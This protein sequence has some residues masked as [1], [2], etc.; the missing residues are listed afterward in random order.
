VLTIYFAGAIS[1]GRGDVAH[2][3]QI[4]AALERDGHRVLAGAV[5]AEQVGSDGERIESAAI[6]D[7][8]MGW[9]ADADVLVAE[10]SV[11]STGVGYEIATARYGRGIPVICLY[12]PAYTKRCTAMV[13]G[14]RGIDLIEYD[15]AA[16]MLSRLRS[17]LAKYTTK[18]AGYLRRT[19]A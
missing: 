16:E 2:Y 12:R 9:I 19:P 4:V 5:A 3:R 18:R 8:D 13:S 1:G 17:A 6:F 15:D 14:D 10:V 7:R 11:P